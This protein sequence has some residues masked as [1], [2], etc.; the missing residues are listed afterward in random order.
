MSNMKTNLLVNINPNRVLSRRLHKTHV[1][2]RI[3]FQRTL[4]AHRRAYILPSSNKMLRWK[5]MLEVFQRY[6]A[7]VSYGC[8]KSSSGYCI[9]CNGYIRMLQ[10]SIPNILFVFF[11]RKSQV[12]L[13][14]YCICFIHVA[15]VFIWMLHKLAMAFRCFVSVSD[16]CCK[17]FIYF[18]RML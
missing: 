10:M 16:V 18:G 1:R 7:S 14:G 11:R 13:S 4:P 17:F 15:S 8:C 9:C 5:H 12:C 3:I 6:V 2:I